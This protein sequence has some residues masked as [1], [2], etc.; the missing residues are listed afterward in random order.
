MAQ[1]LVFRL[2]G[3]LYGLEVVRIQEVAE[4][5]PLYFIPRASPCFLGAINL[6]G[7]ILPV[8]DLAA[9]LGFDHAARD[10]RVIVLA[11]RL[12]WMALAVAEVGKIVNINPQMLLKLPRDRQPNGCIRAVVNLEADLVNLLDVEGLLAELDT[13]GQGTGG[14][15][16]G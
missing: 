14:I 2:G 13:A 1:I 16:G 15:N 5:P 7:A 10:S 8:L 12:C 9:F 3:E 4:C 6:H 11:P